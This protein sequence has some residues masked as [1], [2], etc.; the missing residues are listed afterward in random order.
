PEGAI[1]HLLRAHEALDALPDEVRVREARRDLERVIAAA[2]GLFVRASA[3]RAA[4]APGDSIEI[5]LEVVARRPVPVELEEI[6]FPGGEILEV[7]E[8]LPTDEV[9]SYEARVRI[10]QRASITIPSWLRE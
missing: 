10:P 1:P 8:S 7:E 4:V 6:R 5:S 2:A 3:A 9:R